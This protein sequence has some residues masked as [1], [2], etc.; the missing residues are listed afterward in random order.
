[1][2][3]KASPKRKP[4]RTSKGSL[5]EGLLVRLRS[6]FEM[7]EIDRA[8]FNAIT[9]SDLNQ[10]ALSH[11][12][13]GKDDGHFSHKVTTKGITNQKTAGLCWLHASLNL[14]RPR[15]INNLGLENFEFS[16]AYLQ[17]WD[18]L[19]KGNRYLEGVI[20]LRNADPLDRM[21][22]I[23]NQW[24]IARDGGWWGYA[25][26]LIEK[27]GLVPS[28]VMPETRNNKDTRVMSKVLAELLRS[29]A[30]EILRAND[31][32]SEET[33]L[34][35]IKEAAMED[36]YR[37]LSLN[38][39]VPPTEFEWR[40]QKERKEKKTAK[41]KVGVKQDRLT[42][43]KKYTPQSFFKE[44]VG[45]ELSDYFCLYHTPDRPFDKHYVF[46]EQYCTVGT[47]EMNFVNL[48]IEPIKKICL[49]AILANEPIPFGVD[50]GIDQSTKH[51]LMEHKL[52]DYEALFG[53]KMELSKSERKRLCAPRAGHMM[54]II[55]ADL[56]K[57]VTKK[58][59]IENSWGDDKG[60]KGLW[61]LYDSWFDEHVDH[62]IVHKR[63]IPAKTL[64]VFREK[65][66]RLPIWYWD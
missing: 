26:A 16:T 31:N 61:T 50:M 28:S 59:L 22:K 47:D 58:W 35:K 20:E 62:V 52:F 11:K 21:W 25:K 53:I 44:T 7:N 46:D 9:H 41:A 14:L 10:I 3:R 63:H 34:R 55:G 51:G 64:K 23:L 54:A 33:D 40:H 37:F 48:E 6:S 1:M 36:V 43:W 18:L 45:L 32:G 12:L 24:M 57:G 56:K 65:A 4:A 5:S 15:V 29:K 42:A 13:N 30:A 38:L 27:Y 17:F 39:G 60:K 8:R 2:T 66:E 19:E 49:K